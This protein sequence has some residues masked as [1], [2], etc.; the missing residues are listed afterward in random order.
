MIF[1][2]HYS[3]SSGNLYVVTAANGRRLLIECGVTWKKIQKALKYKLDNVVGA[4]C[5]H[6]HADHSCGAE[7]I[8]EAGIDLFASQETLEILELSNQRRSHVLE[9]MNRQSVS[10]EFE[11]FSF[12]VHHDIAG[13]FGFIIHDRSSKPPENLLFVTDTSH[14]TQK[15][16]VA[17]DIIAI[18]A[19]YDKDILAGR[20]ERQ[21]IDETLAKR[22]LVSHMEYHV[23]KRYIKEFCDLSKCRVIHLLHPSADNMDKKAV[24]KEFEDSF[25]V[26]VV[27][28]AGRL[29]RLLT[30]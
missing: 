3:S 2:A 23:A 22:L 29:A 21:E 18:S 17:F 24:R 14:I 15:F 4:I 10:S 9:E 19:S 28:G 5:S 25:F 11:V 12:P 6:G 7:K 1:E 30:S 20:V 27:I 8:I 26:K 13:A 16:G